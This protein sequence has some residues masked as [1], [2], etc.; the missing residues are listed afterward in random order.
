MSTVQEIELAIERLPREQK[1]EI[2]EWLDKLLNRSPRPEGYFADDY[3]AM[4]EERI[5]VEEQSLRV[6]Q[7]PE[8]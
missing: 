1:T 2:R 8:R 7:F 4:D 3:A 5:K 6:P